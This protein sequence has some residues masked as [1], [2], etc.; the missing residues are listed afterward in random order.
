MAAHRL[1]R[2]NMP[3][4]RPEASTTVPNA[5]IRKKRLRPWLLCDTKCGL[6]MDPETASEHLRVIRSLMERA[7]VYRAISGPA[8]LFGGTLALG[9]GGWMALGHGEGTLGSGAFFGI[10]VAIMGLVGTFNLVLLR[11][12][13]R[14]ESEGFVSSGMRLAFRA[15]A[16]AML[17]GGL[18]SH[19]MLAWGGTLALCAVMWVLFYGL[20]LLSM[21]GFAPRSIRR[22]GTVFFL[23]A[24]AFLGAGYWI[25]APDNAVDDL[26]MAGAIMAATF[27][28]LHILYAGVVILRPKSHAESI[29]S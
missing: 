11:R 21:A 6:M 12:R 18:L 2:A 9:V 4:I 16:P 26:R 24:L 22:L 23:A 28:V 10:W 17:A 13:A 25:E 7:T 8:A 19:L 27:G 15:S 1:A 5:A 3:E 20:A 29:H 14:E